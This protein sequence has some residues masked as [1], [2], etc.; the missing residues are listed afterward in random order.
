MLERK[1][2]L[3]ESRGLKLNM[4]SE[5]I[6][7][8]VSASEQ[9]NKPLEQAS[10][11]FAKLGLDVQ[12]AFLPALNAA[13]DAAIRV[14]REIQQTGTA[15]EGAFT[16]AQAAVEAT[17]LSLSRLA[18]A[19][20]L[21][22][23]GMAGN[24]LQFRNPA[25]FQALQSSAKAT[26]TAAGLS[27]QQLADGVI[28][29]RVRE[30]QVYQ[31]EALKAEAVLESLELQ[32]NIDPSA[33]EAQRKKVQEL[34]EITRRA[35]ENVLTGLSSSTTPGGKALADNLKE[36]NR[37]SKRRLKEALNFLCV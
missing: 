8:F 21:V 35:S 2:K 9:I 25:L 22:G 18:Q 14:N 5:Q 28:T 11:Q 4:P 26:Q 15:S 3:A 29:K 10:K 16:R 1:L 36:Q 27:P 12:A 31:Q 6:R 19:Q 20:A 33:I 13:Q 23:K 17:T 37:L 24:E 7:A 34:S 32:P 30:L